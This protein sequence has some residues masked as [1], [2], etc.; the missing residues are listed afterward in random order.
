MPVV[1][2]E[3][4]ITQLLRQALRGGAVNARRPRGTR[5]R[6]RV[7]RMDRAEHSGMLYGV[8]A[9]VRMVRARRPSSVSR[10]CQPTVRRTVKSTRKKKRFRV[11]ERVRTISLS[12]IRF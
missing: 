8:M 1:D 3:L 12:E 10:R 7:K 6:G 2:G 5:G 11:R 4:A 9:G